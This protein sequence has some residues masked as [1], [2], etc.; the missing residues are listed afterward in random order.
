M[1]YII[2]AGLVFFLAL[3]VNFVIKNN[4]IIHNPLPVAKSIN[5]TT[6]Y[7][8]KLPISEVKIIPQIKDSIEEFYINS[9][10]GAVLDCET[11]LML[12]DK[13]ID[14]QSSIASITKLMS[15]LVFLDHNP[16]WDSI[17]EIKEDDRR[18]GGRIYLFT[19][20]KVKVR[21]LFNIS[22][23]GSANT[24]TIA[25]A[26]S[27]GLSIDEF[28]AEMNNKSFEI[29]LNNTYFS[30][31]SGLDYENVSTARDVAILAKIALD[32]Q[33]IN[34][35]LSKNKYELVT[36]GGKKRII[37]NTDELLWDTSNEKMKIIGGKTGHTNAAGYCFVGKFVDEN[38]KEII[39]S[40]LGA[41]TNKDRFLEAKKL[42]QWIYNNYNW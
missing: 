24:A 25:L 17:Y 34:E 4:E 16:G 27:T 37:Y 29:G 1:P 3:D 31:P 41:E 14:K 15:A 32:N 21:D 9:V 6:E 33:D 23:V 2:I 18:D 20:E 12:F 28:I 30:D 11:D 8:N 26:R 38:G 22:L 13:Q 5:A 10:S 40:I 39:T 7:I 19:G 42:S 36:L 35:T